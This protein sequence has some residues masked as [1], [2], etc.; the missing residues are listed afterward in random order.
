MKSDQAAAHA[1]EGSVGTTL[2]ISLS[3][4]PQPQEVGPAKS[5]AGARP[6]AT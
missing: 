2:L 1:I 3:Y 4:K 5:D 6:L